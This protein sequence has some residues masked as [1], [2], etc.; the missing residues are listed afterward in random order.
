[1]ATPIYREFDVAALNAAYNNRAAVPEHVQWRDQRAQQ[2]LVLYAAHRVSRD[3]RYGPGERQRIDFFHAVSPDRPTVAYIHGGYWQYND[4]EPNA[5][6]AAGPLAAGMNVALIEYSLAP[7]AS[8]RTIV[9]EIRTATAD[10]VKRLPELQASP[11]LVVCGHS[12]GG[13][14]AAMTADVPGVHAALAISGLF[15]LEPIRL[16]EMNQK[17]AMSE[18]EARA[19]SPQFLSLPQTPISVAYGL[20][21]LPELQRQSREFAQVLR[22]ADNLG[23]MLALPD[24]DHFSILESLALPEGALCREVCRLA[25]L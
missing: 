22:A 14:L 21:E 9:R 12:A 18:T 16:T 15:D 24:D 23:R 25:G 7:Q 11:T 3:L 1:M 6:V 20:A 17:L 13:H 10:L 2:S 19:H 8:I 5:F 4:K